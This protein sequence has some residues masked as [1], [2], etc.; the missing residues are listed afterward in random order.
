MAKHYGVTVAVC[1]PGRPQ[2]KGVVDK[3]IGYLTQSWWRSAP[4]S[5]PAQ[6]QA[7]LDRWC[8]AVSDRR[9]RGLRTVA[10]LAAGEALLSLPEL[11]FPA[12]YR[13]ERVVSRDALVDFETNR[14]SVAPGHAGQTVEVRARLGELQLEIYTL[15]GHRIARHRRALSGAGQTVR[16]P[17]HASM[18]ERAALEQFTTSKRCPRKPNRPPGQQARAEAA[19]LRGEQAGG[20][21]VDL[22]QYARIAK[23]AGR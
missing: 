22:E 15:A 8:V 19:K 4:V 9:R 21:R 13:Q 20:V 23:V 3:A 14:Y 16:T 17:E 7:D 12:Q 18:L 2:R 11:P 1:P 6:A 10:E 5:T